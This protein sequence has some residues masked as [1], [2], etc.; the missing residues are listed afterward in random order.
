MLPRK[1]QWCGKTLYTSISDSDCQQDKHK[2][3][4]SPFKTASKKQQRVG[5]AGKLAMQSKSKQDA[6]KNT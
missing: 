3:S 6:A 5:E 1:I 4:G 2:Y